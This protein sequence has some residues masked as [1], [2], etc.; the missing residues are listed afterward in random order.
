MFLRT[1]SGSRRGFTLIELLVVVA[2]IALLISI[3][4]PSLSAA[5]EQAKMVKCGANLRSL[6]QAVH[7]CYADYNEYGPT[8]DDGDTGNMPK[9][10]QSYMLTWV[11]V[12]YDL[13]YLSDPKA[14]LCPNDDRPDE[15]ADIRGEAWGKYFVRTMGVNDKQR[16]GTR[17]SYAM[18]IHM[19]FNF[20]ADRHADPSRQVYAID[21]WWCWFGSLN[22]AWLMA[23]RVLGTPP[24]PH[25]W[26][27]DYATMVGWRHG[28]D[29]RAESLYRD[30]HVATLTP[31]PPRSVG[32]LFY[33][34]VDTA[35]S[36]TWL[37]GETSTRI[38]GG[39][40]GQIL[41]GQGYEG[42]IDEFLFP[43]VEEPLEPTWVRALEGKVGAKR[44]G[45][46]DNIHPF[47]FPEELSATWRT[48]R[49]LW[50]KL[51]NNSDDRR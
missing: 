22:A 37:P 44:L 24:P 2:I 30:G 49:N 16:N 42:H 36:F 11:D 32:D 13:N 17:T 26:P 7:S 34:T 38:P 23:P 18:N 28:R 51:P 39:V 50:T 5:R 45:G 8:W 6:G 20:P 3:L 47:A 9:P 10:A 41:G 27:N 4:L 43:Y 31:K 48:N 40:Y 14:G 1:V 19:H 12:L 35:R 46:G 15:P 25:M 29:H 21:G 33:Y